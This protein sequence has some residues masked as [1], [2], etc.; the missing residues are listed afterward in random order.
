MS[1][2]DL[3]SI[4]EKMALF[5]SITLP[6][7][8]FI[9]SLMRLLGCIKRRNQGLHE[10]VWATG[11]TMVFCMASVWLAANLSSIQNWAL[12]A[13]RAANT[14]HNGPALFVALGVL[15]TMR[16]VVRAIGGALQFVA[17]KLRATV[18]SIFSRGTSK[19]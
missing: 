16:P 3:F 6:G 8:L 5:L 18:G 19:K 14:L 11:Y 12:P 13:E 7:V 9:A 4:G 10:Y 17:G 2:A 15:L 1:G